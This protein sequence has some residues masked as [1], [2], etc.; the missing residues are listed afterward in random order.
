MSA[1]IPLTWVPAY[2]GTVWLQNAITLR[3]ANPVRI[4]V[5]MSL[6][7]WGTASSNHH[8]SLGRQTNISTWTSG[9]PA[10]DILVQSGTGSAY[11]IHHLMA[12]IQ[13]ESIN[14]TYIDMSIS[15]Q[16]TCKYCVYLR[17]NAAATVGNNIG[18]GSYCE[19]TLEEL[20]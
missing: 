12:G 14:F 1:S 10:Y 18:N 2:N 16:N 19:I 8:I 11:G 9:Y 17:S 20:N 5:N 13:Y 7:K 6:D 15:S 3:G 4:T